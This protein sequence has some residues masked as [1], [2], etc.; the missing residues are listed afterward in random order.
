MRVVLVSK[1]AIAAAYQRKAEALAALGIDLTVVVPPY[2]HD[3][4]GRKA[5]LERVNPT[6]YRLVV[7]PMVFNG[8]F[9]YHFYP[10]LGRR[11]RELRP[12]IVHM[13]EEPYNLATMQALWLAR[14][15]GARSIFFT[16]QNLLR[17]YPPPFRWVERYCYRQAAGAI[18][19]NAE[20]VDV[21]RH[22]GYAGLT[23]V[24]PQVGIDPRV[25]YR[26]TVADGAASRPFTVGFCGRLRP[27]KGVHLLVEAV[28]ALGGDAR[29]EILGWGQEEPRLRALAEAKGLSGR[30]TIHPALPSE[31]VP[32][33]LSRLDVYVQPS[34]TFPNWKEQFGR[35]LMEAMACEVAVAGSDSG[36]IAHVIGDAGL[37]FPEG[38]VA[39][40]TEC[41]RRLRDD[42]ELR[43]DLAARGLARARERYTQAQIAA[44]TLEAYRAVAGA[45]AP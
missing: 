5:P 37:L 1:A 11:L 24:I 29:L 15:L 9:H 27:Q 31:R 16:W 41:L 39:A 23:W 18:A 36:E 22:K 2:W 28:A 21:L 43:R 10:R 17:F 12:D 34:L 33:F 32:E 44:Q 6:G 30:F 4:A 14:R 42:L 3:D 38:D 19:G 13:E 35:V 40:M 7:E 8:H 26:R 25:F 45:A 20:A